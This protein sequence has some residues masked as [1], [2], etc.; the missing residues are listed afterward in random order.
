MTRESIYAGVIIAC[1]T[2]YIIE[3]NAGNEHSYTDI[4]SNC[5]SH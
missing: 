2:D 4:S 3:K 5:C 1:D